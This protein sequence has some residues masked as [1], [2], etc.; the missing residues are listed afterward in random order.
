MQIHIEQV[1]K[2]Y[3]RVRALDGVALQID[4]G[5]IVALVGANGAGKTTLLRC[6]GCV[7]SPG[8][9]NVLVDG[10]ILRRNRLDLRRRILFLPDFP[11]VY[12]HMNPLRH[13]GMV[14]RL[15]GKDTTDL[16]ERASDVLG[17]LDLL[18][19][20]GTSLQNLSRGQA[21]KVALAALF[22]V[23]PD[24]W[25]LDEPLASGI[26]PS[27]LIYLKQTCRA[28][29]ARGRTIVYSTQI[30]DVAEKFSDRICILDGG[31]V[32]FFGGVDDIRKMS[33]KPD[34]TLEDIFH[35]LREV[36]M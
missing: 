1:F 36:S 35:Q 27:G 28:A 18:P 14:L 30:L 25:L 15:Y 23:D 5:Q 2:K 20:I 3:G 11:V 13:I 34:G 4:P 7:V 16:G 10:Q 8:K 22:L 29:A 12:G 21:Y 17:N 24:L 31:L 6:L 26:D 33:A 32:K 9:G 19:L